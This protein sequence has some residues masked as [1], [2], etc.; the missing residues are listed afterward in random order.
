LLLDFVKQQGHLS[1]PLVLVALLAVAVGW[2]WRRPA[3]RVARWYLTVVAVGYWFVATSIGSA[4]VASVLIRGARPIATRDEARGADTLVVLG[5][6]VATASVGGEVG[7]V[8]IAS[9]LLRALEGARVAKLIGARRVIVS[10]GIVRAERLPESRMLRAVMVTSGIPPDQIIEESQSTTTREQAYF[11]RAL[12]GDLNVPRFVLVTSKSH[13]WRALA[14]FR[15]LGLDPIPSAAPLP[16]EQVPQPP[17]LLP[18]SDSLGLA[19]DAVYEYAALA[20]YWMRG[21]TRSP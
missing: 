3:S 15:G 21:W 7:G 13:M 16:S 18:N 10:G 9:S 12:L 11:V 14:A 4:V 19:D 2:L 5:G 8:P 17:P 1:S 6:G 20:Y